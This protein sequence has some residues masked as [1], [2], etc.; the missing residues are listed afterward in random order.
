MHCDGGTDLAVESMTY[1][2]HM[3]RRRELAMIWSDMLSDS[4]PDPTILIGHPSKVIGEHS[5]HHLPDPVATDFRFPKWR[6]AA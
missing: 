4:L 6:K 3:P 5:R 1:L 2:H